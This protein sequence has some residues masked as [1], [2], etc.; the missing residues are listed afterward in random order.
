M[1]TVDRILET[2]ERFTEHLSGVE[3]PHP[4][5]TAV[6]QVGDAIEVAGK[7]DRSATDDP[8][9]A[10]IE[11]SLTEMLEELSTECALYEPSTSKNAR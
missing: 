7:R 9:L 6:V 1:P 3:E 8:V 11:K 2:V 5:M 10:A 4:P